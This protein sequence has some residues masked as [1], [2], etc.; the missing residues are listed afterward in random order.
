M[1]E[2][3][4]EKC[5]E[6]HRPKKKSPPHKPK[7]H[8]PAKGRYEGQ[9]GIPSNANDV[10]VHADLESVLSSLRAV[11]TRMAAS[12]MFLN[13]PSP[14]LLIP[15]LEASV[16]KLDASG[17]S[18]RIDSGWVPCTKG[19]NTKWRVTGWLVAGPARLLAHGAPQAVRE[20]ES[21]SSHEEK[22]ADEKS[23]N[24]ELHGDLEG[25]VGKEKIARARAGAGGKLASNDA[26]ATEHKT[27]SDTH[28]GATLKGPVDEEKYVAPISFHY[29]VECEIDNSVIGTTTNPPEPEDG[30]APCGTI[31]Y[32]ML[33]PKE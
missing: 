15:G 22:A 6:P 32:S 27:V 13:A 29:I 10:G 21:K 20:H 12:S 1:S 18:P 28:H 16:N 7:V 33:S 5:L 17:R 23:D 4:Q 26:H 31:N 30:L 8:A 2:Q 25:E 19:V 24:M 3:H 9:Q 14:A 11:T